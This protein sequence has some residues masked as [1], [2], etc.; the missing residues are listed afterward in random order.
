MSILKLQRN[1]EINPS[2]HAR[3]GA[4]DV[5]FPACFALKDRSHSYVII[6]TNGDMAI[7]WQYHLCKQRKLQTQNYFHR[8]RNLSLSLC[9]WNKF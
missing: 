4:K 9:I 3:M 6:V 7:I 5:M 8:L 2:M 1:F